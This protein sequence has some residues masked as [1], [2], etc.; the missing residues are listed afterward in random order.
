L[1]DKEDV[2]VFIAEH[3]KA[4]WSDL[5]VFF[6]TSPRAK[7]ENKA[8]CPECGGGKLMR[9]EEGEVFCMNCGYVLTLGGQVSRQTLLNFIYTLIRESTI[10]KVIDQ[11]TYR[12]VYRITQLAEKGSQ[13]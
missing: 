12:P 9:N 10:E 13:P 3:G 4:S 1:V 11:K 5:E 8:A 2:A 6:A 7:G